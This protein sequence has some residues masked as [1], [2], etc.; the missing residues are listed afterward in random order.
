MRHVEARSGQEETRMTKN[1]FIKVV[2]SVGEVGEA[3]VR[4]RDLTAVKSMELFTMLVEVPGGRAVRIA[5]VSVRLISMRPC[6]IVAQ[7][8]QHVT[9]SPGGCCPAVRSR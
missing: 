4:K 8:S 2:M 6:A 7:M 5:S 9:T 1:Y 3:P